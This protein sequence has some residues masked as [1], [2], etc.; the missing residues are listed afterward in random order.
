M[1][2]VPQRPPAFT[3]TPSSLVDVGVLLVEGMAALAMRLRGVGRR[4]RFAAQDIDAGRDRFQVSWVDAGAVPA[5]VVQ[6]DA[7]RNWS[8]D[9]FIT[10]AMSALGAPVD[11]E[12]AVALRE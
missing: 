1:R 12:Q 3:T 4:G 5:K 8:N 2:G 11:V 7:L 10:D 9:E 6:V